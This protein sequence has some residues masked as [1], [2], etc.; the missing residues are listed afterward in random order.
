MDHLSR[1]GGTS[2]F[3]SSASYT[4]L[5]CASQ[6]LIGTGIGQI[7]YLNRAL[8][9][10]DSKVRSSL[11]VII[12]R[13]DRLPQVVVPTQFV[14]F[15]ISAIV[16]S[17]ILY[18]DFARAS[19]HQIVTFL[20]GCGATFAGVFIIAWAPTAPPEPLEEDEEGT[21]GDAPP[22]EA[23]GTVTG[24]S[25][26]SGSVAYRSRVRILAADGTPATPILR[27]RQSI[28][29]MYGLS[30]AQVRRPS[31]HT[32]SARTDD[33]TRLA[34]AAPWPGLTASGRRLPPPLARPRAQPR[35]ARVAAP[36]ADGELARRQWS[37]ELAADA[38]RDAGE[39]DAGEQ[40]RAR[41]E[42]ERGRGQE[43][44][45]EPLLSAGG[46][47]VVAIPWTVHTSCCYLSAYCTVPP[48]GGHTAYLLEYVQ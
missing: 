1:V 4:Q 31:P 47:V 46:G 24:L 20:Y 19:F 5:I 9:R 36:A 42:P 44:E 30:P 15:N 14:L 13:A 22:S 17:A 34:C 33:V 40:P 12:P 37:A 18:G 38:R 6:V 21:I 35:V 3:S 11:L 8:M 45:P 28:V 26:R 29:S 43:R 41:A 27:N 39:R 2:I 25:S 23:E 48:V 16:G 10:F 32:E 7:R